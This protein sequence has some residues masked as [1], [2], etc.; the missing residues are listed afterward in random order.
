MLPALAVTILFG[1]IAGWTEFILAV[2]FL[3][4]ESRLNLAVGPCPF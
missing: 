2:L 4:N 3:S 1:F